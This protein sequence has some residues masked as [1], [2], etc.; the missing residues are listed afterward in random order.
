[1]LRMA[2]EKQNFKNKGF[3]FV[4]C[5]WNWLSNVIILKDANNSTSRS[6]ERSNNPWSKLFTEIHKISILNT[7]QSVTFKEPE[8]R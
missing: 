2:L 7:Q 8:A 3:G 1:M 5:L 6:K 4:L